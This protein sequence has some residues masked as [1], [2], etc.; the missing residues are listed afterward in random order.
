MNI[1]PLILSGDH[2]ESALVANKYRIRV[3]QLTLQLSAERQVQM[4]KLLRR[5]RGQ[6]KKGELRVQCIFAVVRAEN[7]ERRM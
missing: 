1:S 6:R 3:V 5:V 4:S 2:A 7:E